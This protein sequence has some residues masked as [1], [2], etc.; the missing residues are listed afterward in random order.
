[1]KNDDIRKCKYCKQQDKVSNLVKN[2]KIKKDRTP[3]LA[4]EG[5]YRYEYYHENCKQK[6]E[7]NKKERDDFY[8]YLV[9]L[10]GASPVPSYLLK[11]L[12]SYVESY[13]YCNLLNCLIWI[14]PELK[15]CKT[16]DT[17]HLCNLI[18]YMIDT[19]I[20]DYIKTQE[21]SAME[22]IK[23]VDF[24]NREEKTELEVI[25]YNII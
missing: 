1:M 25:D 17:K 13:G 22:N 10:I 16:N 21:L 7:Q 19:K 24:L 18:V 3:Q 9:E 8:D 14:T 11:R 6:S 15:K 2:I 20:I 23:M 4:S 12:S 5:S